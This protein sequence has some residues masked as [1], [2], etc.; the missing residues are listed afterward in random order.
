V[1]AVG[2]GNRDAG[3]ER[4]SGPAGLGGREAGAGQH[5]LLQAAET[6]RLDQRDLQAGHGKSRHDKLLTIAGTRI[7]LPRDA[8]P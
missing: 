5:G 3:V 1:A 4:L 2:G 6:G 7:V 8:S